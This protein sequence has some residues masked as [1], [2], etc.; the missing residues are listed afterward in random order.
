MKKTI[1]TLIIGASVL[2][3]SCASQNNQSQGGSGGQQR[4]GGQGGAPN[5]S[6]L[7]SQM[8]ANKDGKLSKSEVKGRL[9]ND[10]SRIDSNSD[11]FI[12]DS[13]MENAPRPQRGRN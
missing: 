8:D 6:Q 11:G 12:T 7:L 3:A 1:R 4:S 2:F 5:F 9:V 13:E 10:F